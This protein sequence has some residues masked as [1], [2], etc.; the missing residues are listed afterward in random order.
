MSASVKSVSANVMSVS[1][2][3]PWDVRIWVVSLMDTV[4]M[5][6]PARRRR[7][8]TV[9]PSMSSKPS[10]R[11]MYAVLLIFLYLLVFCFIFNFVFYFVKIYLVF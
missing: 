10:A 3:M 9:K 2:V 11:K 7:S 5:S 1:M 8:T 6:I 4:L